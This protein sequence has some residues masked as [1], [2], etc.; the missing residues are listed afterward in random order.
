MSFNKSFCDDDRNTDLAKACYYGKLRKVKKLYRKGADITIR[1]E[2]GGTLL[3]IACEKGKTKIAVFLLQNG[4]DI[5]AKN[6]V[7]RTPLHLASKSKKQS[8]TLIKLLLDNGAYINAKDIFGKTP[9]HIAY[10]SNNEYG[11]KYLNHFGADVI[12][13]DNDNNSPYDLSEDKFYDDLCDLCRMGDLDGVERKLKIRKLKN[14]RMHRYSRSALCYASKLGNFS[15]AIA[16]AT[17]LLDNGANVNYRTYDSIGPLFY[18]A[19]AR[20]I[21]LVKLLVYRGA[22]F[23]NICSEDGITLIGLAINRNHVEYSDDDDRKDPI[24]DYRM[25]NFLYGIGADIND[26]CFMR[27]E[28]PIHYATDH[29]NYVLASYLIQKGADLDVQDY[30]K[31]TPLHIATENGNCNFVSFLIKNGANISIK[32]KKMQTP[33]DIARARAEDDPIVLILQKAE[34]DS[35]WNPRSS[36][37]L[38]VAGCGF[39]PLEARKAFYEKYILQT[40][41]IDTL[42]KRHSYNVGQILSNDGLLRL[43]ISFL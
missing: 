9:L 3:H 14:P 21:N 13:K 1:N 16:I 37:M 27:R 32:N 11:F 36:L 43:I 10:E 25:L 29:R 40:I 41:V 20:N 2:H 33:L 35:I 39:R 42:A 6:N 7:D 18:A 34:K 23:N 26:S 17:L 38:L 4:L 19:E 8:D 12:A 15:K 22:K 24:P 5:N 31:R 30:Y 28:T